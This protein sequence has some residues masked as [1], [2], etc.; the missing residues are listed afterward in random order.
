[1]CQICRPSLRRR[2]LRRL[3]AAGSGSWEIFLPAC[4]SEQ[5]SRADVIDPAE[6]VRELTSDVIVKAFRLGSVVMAIGLVVGLW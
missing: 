5:S 6:D 4:F 2:M 3:V 1:M